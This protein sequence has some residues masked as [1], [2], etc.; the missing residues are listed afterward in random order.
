MLTHIMLTK[1]KRIDRCRRWYRHFI[2]LDESNERTHSPEQP[3]ICYY[4][5]IYIFICIYD[6]IYNT[7]VYS[8]RILLYCIVVVTCGIHLTPNPFAFHVSLYYY[9]IILSNSIGTLLST[10]PTTNPLNITPTYVTTPVALTGTYY[11]TMK[12]L[13][14]IHGCPE[15]SSPGV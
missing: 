15:I 1:R 8:Y 12:L 10:I 14:E 3:N 6:I 13:H 7:I 11:I 9:I 4:N 5:N 2:R